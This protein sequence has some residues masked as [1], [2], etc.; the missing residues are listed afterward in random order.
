[1]VTTVPVQHHEMQ[2]HTL[3]GMQ[4]GGICFALI[5]IYEMYLKRRDLAIIILKVYH[6]SV[7]YFESCSFTLVLYVAYPIDGILY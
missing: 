5:C 6:L 4:A 3:L 1:M 7:V 2:F